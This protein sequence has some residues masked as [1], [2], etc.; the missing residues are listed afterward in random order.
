LGVDNPGSW[1]ERVPVDIQATQRGLE[2]ERHYVSSRRHGRREEK[3]QADT[4][5]QIARDALAGSLA[6]SLRQSACFAHLSTVHS[7]FSE[8]RSTEHSSGPFA[9]R[10]SRTGRSGILVKLDF[11][12]RPLVPNSTTGVGS[13]VLKNFK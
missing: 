8:S 1:V 2:V 9:S 5:L 3:S 10:G 13:Y 11:I 12:S 6:R 4:A 7:G